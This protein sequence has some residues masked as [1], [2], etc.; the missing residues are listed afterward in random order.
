MSI[1]ASER[2]ALEAAACQVRDNAY[3]PYSGFRVGAA[4]LAGSGAIYSGVNVENAAYNPTI[5]AE[6]A[7]IFA[8]ISAGER[9]LRAVAVCTGTGATPCGP[10]RQ[11]MRE[12]ARDLP[13]YIIDTA[14]N[15]RETSLSALLPDAFGPEDLP[16]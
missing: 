5:C 16:A 14:G 4:V 6:R 2:T 8:A 11:V 7:A 15:S 10:C 13:V 1:T 12:F 3:A 9:E